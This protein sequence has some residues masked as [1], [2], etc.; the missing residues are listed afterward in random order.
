MLRLIFVETDDT[1]RCKVNHMLDG[2][3]DNKDST[4]FMSSSLE[5]IYK[6]FDRI[7]VT[8]LREHIIEEYTHILRILYNCKG[9]CNLLNKNLSIERDKDE[10][11]I[12]I[13]DFHSLLDMT[14]SHVILYHIL[15]H[16]CHN[17]DLLNK[18]IKKSVYGTRK[19]KLSDS[20]GDHYELYYLT[21][22]NED[23]NDS[24]TV[25]K[26]DFG[27][28]DI[29]CGEK[30]KYL[31][32]NLMQ[33][34]NHDT[35]KEKLIYSDDKNDDTI[36]EYVQ[37][38]ENCINKFKLLSVSYEVKYGYCS[39]KYIYIQSENKIIAK[40]KVISH[41]SQVYRYI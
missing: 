32:D 25:Y 24:E 39:Y 36:V 16:R 12:D 18:Y 2:I 9:S 35:I 33:Y 13:T 6:V 8:R 4:D 30:L 23:T 40:Q 19:G 21:D 22:R 27:V 37:N 28:N 3:C 7:D 31:Y 29:C 17:Y 34:I 14:Y 10:E 41:R 5:D 38:I 1:D 11:E 20:R 26:L 15:N